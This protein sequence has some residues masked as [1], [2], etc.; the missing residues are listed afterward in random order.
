MF[1]CGGGLR[2]AAGRENKHFCFIHKAA[3]IYAY[4]SGLLIVCNQPCWKIQTIKADA[5]EMT[6]RV[7]V[8][9]KPREV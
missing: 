7:H 6:Q 5:F 8:I 3:F 4:A 9:C 2:P 1:P